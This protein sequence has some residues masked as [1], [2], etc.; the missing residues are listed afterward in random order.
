LKIMAL[1]IPLIFILQFLFSIFYFFG[2]LRLKSGLNYL[3][4]PIQDSATK[5]SVSIIISLHNEETNIPSLIQ[6]LTMQKYPN[7]LLEIIFVDDRSEDKTYELLSKNHISNFSVKLLKIEETPSDFAPKKYAITQAVSQASGE[8]LLFTDADGRPGPTWVSSMV[9]HFSPET[10]MVLG[11]AP[12]TT[13]HPFNKTIFRILALEYLSHA[14]VS[15]ASTGLN[16]PVT[17]VGTNL[18]YRKTVFQQLSGYGKFSAVHT[19]DDDLFLQRVREETDWEIRYAT[20]ENS[21]V[22]NAPP[23]KLSKFYDQRLRY[24]S[25][26]FIYPL[27]FKSILIFF[28]FYNL[29]YLISLVF[30]M[31]NPSWFPVYLI[32]LLIKYMIDYSF[33][34]R[35][36]KSLHDRRHLSMIPVTLMFHIPYVIYFGLVS[37][38]QN[39]KW[40]G[41][42]G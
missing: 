21:H 20:A 31:I 36:A 40:A 15:A 42:K 30:M 32:A 22:F 8:I 24:A 1:F 17:C 5:P 7:D 35:A 18:A 41:R 26:G 16:Y 39:F 13:H 27:K 29:L 14:A 4:Y 10:G 37:Q 25:K 23:E 12:Y 3:S 11:Y 19:G 33:M 28:Y 34:H 2:Y 6:H 38:I 9:S